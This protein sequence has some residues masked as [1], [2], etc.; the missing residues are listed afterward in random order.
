MGKLCEWGRRGASPRLPRRP[1][2]PAQHV[3]VP[4]AG[5]AEVGEHGLLVV[6]DRLQGAAAV[7][8][9][10]QGAAD[11]LSYEGQLFDTR[12]QL[13]GAE[14]RL[15]GTGVRQVAWFKGYLA[16]LYLPQAASTAQ[17]GVIGTAR[18]SVAKK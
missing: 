4:L 3:P 7:A 11:K 18:A 14:L 5:P 16:A 8:N 6:A 17:Q 15:N 9:P 13:L 1:Q 10:G 2:T 12:I